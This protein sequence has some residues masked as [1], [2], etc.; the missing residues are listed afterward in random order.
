MRIRLLA[1]AVCF[2]AFTLITS[3]AEAQNNTV[4]EISV[5]FWRPTPDLVISTPAITG[6]GVDE[7]DF[8]SE[9]GI[10]QK[11]FP[12]FRA[13]LGHKHKF[14]FGYVPIKYDASA[15]IRRTITLNGRTFNVGAPATT[16]IKWDLWRFGYEWDFVSTDSGFFGLIA[17]LKYN[18]VTASIDSPALARASSTEQKAP[19]PTIGAIGRGYIAPQVA[20]SAEFTAL[21]IDRSEFNAKFYDFDVNAFVTFGKYIGAQGGY[22]AVTVDYLVDEDTGDL[23]MQGPYAGVILRF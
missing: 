5:L 2:T 7:I 23:K 17:D 15:T 18:K 4:G 14:R 9:F 19:V 16:E 13:T 3:R 6:A 12:E 11:W 1:I 10:E 21:K 20:I 22:R 8:V